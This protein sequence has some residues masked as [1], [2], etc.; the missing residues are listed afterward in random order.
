VTVTT[1]PLGHAG[2][3]GQFAATHDQAENKLYYAANVQLPEAGRWRIS[4]QVRSSLGEGASSFE[5][6]VAPSF[7]DGPRFLLLRTMLWFYLF[8]VWLLD[9][10]SVV[11]LIVAV[12]VAMILWQW[13]RSRQDRSR[14]R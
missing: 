8:R 11:A 7:L 13:R 10:A 9:H 1:E 6:E 3:K 2:Q 14:G 5:I 12:A 4:V